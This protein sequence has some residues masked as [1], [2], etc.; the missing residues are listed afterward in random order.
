[1]N[2][3]AIYFITWR[4]L[5]L[6]KSFW[7]TMNKIF[8]YARPCSIK[9]RVQFHFSCKMS[10]E[11][12]ASSFCLN[13]AMWSLFWT[14]QTLLRELNF[15]LARMFTST[16]VFRLC[17]SPFSPSICTLFCYVFITIYL[18]SKKRIFSLTILKTGLSVFVQL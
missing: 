3:V 5:R 18:N 4:A 6:C 16:W 7:V 1:M 12:S 11:F 14:I 2:Y 13:F 15:C 8:M 17:L 9:W 10:A